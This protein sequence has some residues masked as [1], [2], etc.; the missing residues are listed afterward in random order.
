MKAFE[1]LKNPDFRESF[2]MMI[3]GYIDKQFR[4][5]N[6]PIP[7]PSSLIPLDYADKDLSRAVSR[8]KKGGEVALYCFDVYSEKNK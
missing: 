1:L 5:A 6:K 2:E 4:D 3:K 8:L 7:I